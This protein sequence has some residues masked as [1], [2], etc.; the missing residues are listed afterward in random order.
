M[1]ANRSY[2]SDDPLQI[3][4]TKIASKKCC[5]VQIRFTIDARHILL[6]I[7]CLTEEEKKNPTRSMVEE[8]L[9]RSLYDNGERWFLSPIDYNEEGE[10]YNCREELEK[11]VPTARTLFPEFMDL[12]TSVQ[13]IRDLA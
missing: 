10:H 8:Q 12:P 3:M 5:H 7:T 4:D 13:F 11:A 6:A 1:K 2:R 9:R